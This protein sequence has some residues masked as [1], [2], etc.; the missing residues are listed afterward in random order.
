MRDTHVHLRSVFWEATLRCNAGC[1]FCG[2]RCGEENGPE[3]DGETVYNTF[4]SISRSYDPA[5]IMI[6]VTGGEPLLRKDLFE[7]MGR[8]RLLGFPWGM[9]TNGSL[10]TEEKIRLMK[11]TGMRTISVSIDDLFEAHEKLRRLP[12]GAF[13]QIM[14]MLQELDREQFLDTI[15]ITTVVN[16]NNIGSLEAMLEYFRRLPVDSWRLA[17]VDPIGRCREQEDLLL[18]SEELDRFFSFLKRH[19]FNA[20]PVLTTSCSHY[21]GSR[22]NLYRAH[23]FHCEAGKNVVSILADGS[24]FVCPNV[25]R[26]KELI[27]GNITHDD[28]V[29]IWE[30]GFQWFR[31]PDNRRVGDCQTCP[32]WSRC[33]G[34]SLHTWDFDNNKPNFCYRRYDASPMDSSRQQPDPDKI[35]NLRDFALQPDPDKNCNLRSFEPQPDTDM[36]RNQRSFA[37]QPDTDMI[38]NLKD[39]YPGVKGIRISYGSSSA[40]TVVFGP[41]AAGQ[42]YHFFHWGIK[43]PAN[44]CEQMMAAAGYVREDRAWIEELI[45]VPLINRSE[46]T[47]SFHMELHEYVNSEIALMNRNLV[48]CNDFIQEPLC[49]LGYIHSHPGELEASMSM[50]DLEFHS[51]LDPECKDSYFTGIINPHSKDLCIYWDSIYYPVHVI[52]FVDEND[53]DHWI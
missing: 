1:P 31:N 17:I 16:R 41:D 26:R 23:S 11:E 3:V 35:C 34:D 25:P 22:D 19:R 8:V 6:N 7:V 2:S 46:K 12:K 48:L 13:Q 10:I 36:I 32:E 39:R 27:Q 49:L 42:L 43:H 21:L 51:A 15:Q 9:V 30:E 18:R 37:L 40:K 14:K 5:Q 28:F 50:P 20:K 29:K 53:V 38:R 45:P 24:V 33:R 44:I 4:A 47:A 52:L